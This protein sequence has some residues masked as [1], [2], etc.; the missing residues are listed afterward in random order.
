VD[1]HTVSSA[2]QTATAK[3]SRQN[4]RT[5]K[6]ENLET[7]DRTK[8]TKGETTKYNTG[9]VDSDSNMWTKRNSS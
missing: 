8:E 3:V 4:T 5:L 2:N 9:T 6:T 7:M 1:T